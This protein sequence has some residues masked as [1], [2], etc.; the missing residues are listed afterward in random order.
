MQA[1]SWVVVRDWWPA[2][3]KISPGSWQEE[4]ADNIL[5]EPDFFWINSEH[6]GTV[7]SERPFCSGGEWVEWSMVGVSQLVATGLFSRTFKTRLRQGWCWGLPFGRGLALM[8][9]SSG[10]SV[11]GLLTSCPC[12][13][14]WQLSG[15][16]PFSWQRPATEETDPH[17]LDRSSQ[18]CPGITPTMPSRYDT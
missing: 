2:K 15:L 16:V 6:P 1:P 8:R 12:N 4:L 18:T 7:L 14:W 11:N 10:S 3:P 9:P 17:L 13:F 5:A